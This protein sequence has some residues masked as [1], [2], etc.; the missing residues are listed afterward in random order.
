MK[1]RLINPVLCLLAAGALAC[2]S[3][4]ASDSTAA[5]DSQPTA[6]ATEIPAFN[7]DSA[8]ANVKAQCHLGPRVLGSEAHV[9]CAQWLESRLKA[10]GA[11]VTVHNKTITDFSG[12]TY[13]L[14]NIYAR[15]NPQAQ[16]R[17]LLA[18][19]WD[20]RPWADEDPDPANHKKPIDGAND[21]ASGVGVI[22][23]IARLAAATPPAVGIDIL[24]TDGE[25][26]GVSAP[27]NA[28]DATILRYENSWC[29]GVQHFLETDPYATMTKPVFGILLDMVGGKG[30]SFPVEYFSSRYARQYVDKV[31]AAAAREGT[32]GLFPTSI[33]GAINDDHVH[34]NRAGIPTVN[35]IDT[36]PGTATGFNPTWHTLAD[37]MTNI[38]PNVLG[39][40][41]R[42]VTNLIYNETSNQQ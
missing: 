2:S 7:A 4:A 18:A 31:T 32:A 36:R 6:A 23:E 11:E 5:T 35:I 12:N 16:R 20:T 17:V 19:H 37:N 27:D 41:G 22:L 42:T 28:D 13:Q 33:S 38:D 21:G 34:L 14:A 3:K 29:L 30:A 40:V 15:L 8:F 39:A 25:D 9:R 1:R 10:I 24:L 26:S